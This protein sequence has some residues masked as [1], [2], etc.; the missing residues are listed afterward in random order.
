[1]LVLDNIGKSGLIGYLHGIHLD[2][3]LIHFAF[4]FFTVGANFVLGFLN[5]PVPYLVHL[6]VLVS[7]F[8]VVYSVFFCNPLSP[9][10]TNC[11]QAD[12][13]MIG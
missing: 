13:G 5:C 6:T 7:K 4:S 8:F 3:I 9:F 1:M 12:V 2:T 10:L 11:W